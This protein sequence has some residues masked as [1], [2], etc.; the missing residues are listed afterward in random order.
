MTRPTLTLEE[1]RDALKYCNSFNRLPTLLSISP[2]GS[3]GRMDYPDWYTLLGEEWS[4]CDNIGLYRKDLKFCMFLCCTP[5]TCPE[6]MGEQ[7][8]AALAAL[9]ERVTIYRGCG[10]SNMIGCCWSLDRDIAASFPYL[11]RYQQDEPLLVTAT[12]KRDRIVA[13]KLDRNEQEVIT[14]NAR[15]VSVEPLAFTPMA[16][17]M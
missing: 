2:I 10:P 16:V 11:N 5:H 14:F 9:P 17:E 6:M 4:V 1:G 13:L 8:R 7:E 3:V 12:V 15:R